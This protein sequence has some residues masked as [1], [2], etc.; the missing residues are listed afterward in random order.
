MGNRRLQALQTL[1]DQEH[2]ALLSGALDAIAP[3][4]A[5]KEKLLRQIPTRGA[6]PAD[7][8]ALSRSIARNQALLTAATKGVKAAESAL[9]TLQ[10]AT[11]E[12]VVYDKS[13]AVSRMGQ[14][15]KGL[16]QKM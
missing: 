4:T 9:A 3:M 6:S 10:Q 2:A 1:L 14:T 12:S 11:Q 16:S 5:A 8:V 13:G 15:G 7:L